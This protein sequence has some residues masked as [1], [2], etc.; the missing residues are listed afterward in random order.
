MS[1]SNCLWISALV[2]SR[3]KISPASATTRRS[4]GARE[5]IAKKA[6]EAAR[7]R[8]LSAINSTA[9]P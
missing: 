8:P 5:K 3:P 7:T 2:W 6:I 4:R 1:D 9:A